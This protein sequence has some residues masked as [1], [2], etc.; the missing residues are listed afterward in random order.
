MNITKQQNDTAVKS[1]VN[2]TF[3]QVDAKKQLKTIGDQIEALA[4]KWESQGSKMDCEGLY[5]LGNQVEHF[6]DNADA[7]KLI[8]KEPERSATKP[9][10]SL[11]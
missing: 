11:S 10:T 8:A 5:T 4:K 7:A 3:N 9:S 6:L 1:P 2:S